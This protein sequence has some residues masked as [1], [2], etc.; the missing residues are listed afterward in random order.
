M[1][2][3]DIPFDL[4]HL[5]TILRLRLK[6]FN[7]KTTTRARYNVN[8]LKAKEVRTAFHRSV[9]NRFQ[10]L[11]DQLKDRETSIDTKWQHIKEL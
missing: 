7:N 10:P 4:H 1:R 9:S 6:K 3:A 11:Q 5:M 8:L 2:G